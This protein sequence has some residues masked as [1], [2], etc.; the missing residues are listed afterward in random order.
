ML[1]MVESGL[2]IGFTQPV[3]VLCTLANFKQCMVDQ[4]S[5]TKHC[6]IVRLCYENK[7]FA[8]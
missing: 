1:G 2:L 5:A 6:Y 7:Q 4:V 3:Q 8:R